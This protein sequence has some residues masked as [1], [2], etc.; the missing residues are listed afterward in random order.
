MTS[1]VPCTAALVDDEVLR[2]FQIIDPTTASGKTWSYRWG[3]ALTSGQVTDA[4]DVGFSLNATL[5][6]EDMIAG[7]YDETPAMAPFQIAL[8]DL[9]VWYVL[10]LGQDASGDTTYAPQRVD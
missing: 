8:S 3:S 2:L 4:T 5:R 9:G 10:A 7:G 1:S 6:V